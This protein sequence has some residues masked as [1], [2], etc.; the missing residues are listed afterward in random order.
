MRSILL[1]VGRLD[2]FHK[3]VIENPS[4]VK[5]SISRVLFD[6]HIQEWVQKLDAS[7]SLIRVFVARSM[8]S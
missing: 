4:S 7:S 8:A 2:L 1:S 5:M 3:S 6:L